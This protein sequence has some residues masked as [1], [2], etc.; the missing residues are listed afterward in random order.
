MSFEYWQFNWIC[1]LKINICNKSGRTL[2]PLSHHI[3]PT[4]VLFSTVEET[5]SAAYFICNWSS[6]LPTLFFSCMKSKL[7]RFIERN[8]VKSI[9][10]IGLH[11]SKFICACQ[12][13][14]S[15]SQTSAI[16]IEGLANI[17]FSIAF[18]PSI[19]T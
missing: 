3:P 12:V 8:E 14:Q 7:K 10:N 5:N 6:L 4:A 17:L 13:N 9:H 15:G 1:E 11:A 16:H 2:H 18:S 19:K